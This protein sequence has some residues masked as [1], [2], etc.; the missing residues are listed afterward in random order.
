M[1]DRIPFPECL[2]LFFACPVLVSQPVTQRKSAMGLE[3]RALNVL[4][5][6]SDPNHHGDPDLLPLLA[7]QGGVDLQSQA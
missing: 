7:H 3:Y 6:S 2:N 1:K 5:F 4:A